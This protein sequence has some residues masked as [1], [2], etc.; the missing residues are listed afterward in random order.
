MA[1][2]VGINEL[3]QSASETGSWLIDDSTKDL[4]LSLVVPTPAKAE[5]PKTPSTQA[6][7]APDVAS[8][9]TPHVQT[10]NPHFSPK[11]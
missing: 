9:G 11:N 6:P 3:S 5:G 8:P 10:P 4:Y 7:Q 2:A 1:N